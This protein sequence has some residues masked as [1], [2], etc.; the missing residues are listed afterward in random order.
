MQYSDKAK[1]KIAAA[2]FPRLRE[3]WESTK[4][5]GGKYVPVLP[6]LATTA[7]G[8]GT[9]NPTLAGVGASLTGAGLSYVGAKEANETNMQQAQ[10]QMDF[11]ERMS[12]TQ[13]QR[14]IQDMIKSGI[15]P[16]AIY[17]LGA[18]GG[19]PGASAQVGNEYA[20]AVASALQLHQMQ[21]DVQKTRAE[22]ALTAELA[23]KVVAETQIK[24][25]QAQVMDIVSK[26]LEQVVHTPTY[27]KQLYDKFRWNRM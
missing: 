2:K 3:V 11:Q 12:S 7:V 14:T 5:I 21:A 25:P 27:L 19:A 9:L 10:N 20:S 16:N 15:N 13:Y 18:H 1:V 26:G 4:Q 6:G 8:V 22:T 24:G 23:K 17:S